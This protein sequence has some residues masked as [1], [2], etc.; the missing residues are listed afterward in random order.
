MAIERTKHRVGVFPYHKNRAS[1]DDIAAGLREFADN[2]RLEPRLEEY[3][4]IANKILTDQ[5]ASEVRKFNA[6][7]MLRGIERIKEYLAEGNAELAVFHAFDVGEQC[8]QAMVNNLGKRLMSQSTAAIAR[9]APSAAAT[10]L[11]LD[12]A[13]MAWEEDEQLSKADTIEWINGVLERDGKKPF[14][15]RVLWGKIRRLAPPAV[16]KRGRPPKK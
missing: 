6:R 16:S 10:E 8:M 1:G 14:S 13:K 4:R 11:V 2:Y 12:L 5:Q 7:S 15:D 3:E 9:H